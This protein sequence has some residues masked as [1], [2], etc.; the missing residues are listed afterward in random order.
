VNLYLLCFRL[1]LTCHLLSATVASL[2]HSK[3]SEG[4]HQT[5]LFQQACLFRAHVGKCPSPTLQWSVPHVSYGCKP[6]P[7]QALCEGA[8]KSTFFSRLIYLQFMWGCTSPPFSGA[9]GAPP[10]LLCLLF[11]CLLFS[12]FLFVFCFC[13]VGVS[14]SRGLCWFIPGVAVRILR[15]TYLLTCWSACLKQVR[16]WCLA[17]REPSWFLLVLWCGEDMR[18]LVVW[19]CQ[20]FAASWWFFLPSVSPVSQQDFYFKEHTLSASSL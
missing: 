11:S 4:D 5:H 2:L 7:L 9:Q 6:S 18:G 1:Q 19:R 17:A 12:F 10:S 3:F 14:L 13:E 20:S 8:T 16:N 15:A